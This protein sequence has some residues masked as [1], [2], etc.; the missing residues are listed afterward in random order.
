[1][2]SKR[3]GTPEQGRR[4]MHY[5]IRVRGHLDP[6]WQQRFEGLQI[7]YE[8]AGTTLLSGFLPDQAALHGVLLQIIR[9]GLTLLSLETNGVPP[10]EARER[11]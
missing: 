2:L 3:I 8:D 6:A 4:Q 11:S 7:E 9:L 1:M 5:H 10:Q